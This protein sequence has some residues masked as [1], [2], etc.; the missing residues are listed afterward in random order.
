[1]NRARVSLALL[2]CLAALLAGSPALAEYEPGLMYS[3]VLNGIVMLPDSGQFRMDNVQAVFLPDPG[4]STYYPYDPEGGGRLWVILTGAGGEELYRFN[5]YA[6]KL[7]DPYWLISSYKAVDLRTG[8]DAGVG[9]VDL[10]REGDYLLSWYLDSGLFYTFPFSVSKVLSDDPFVGGDRWFI[11][12]AWEDWA[13]LYYRDADPESSIHFKVW[14]RNKSVGAD[15]DVKPRM[16]VHHAS[17]GLVAT[18]R[19]MTLTLKPKW[20]RFELDL[21]FPMEG[22]SGG[23]YVKA[24]DLLQRDGG[25]ALKLWLDDEYYGEW[26]FGVKG[27][28]LEYYGRAVR[29]SDPL[30]FIEG[31]RDAWW[32]E[33][34]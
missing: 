8:A 20:N 5:C 28:K 18:T 16:E 12:G 7:K 19:M 4:S 14:L 22:T 2:S 25:Y 24:R 9:W 33:R 13:Y 30:T 21:I 32:Y 3:T 31:G 11:D 15:R 26:E 27:G 34:R 17:A 6:E 10:A 23:A 1:M 29:G